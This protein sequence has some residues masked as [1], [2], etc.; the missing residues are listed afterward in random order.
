MG[1]IEPLRSAILGKLVG[2]AQIDGGWGQEALSNH[3]PNPSAPGGRAPQVLAGRAASARGK[4]EWVGR[5][6]LPLDAQHLQTAQRT[7]DNDWGLADRSYL[8]SFR[9]LPHVAYAACSSSGWTLRKRAS[10]VP[11]KPWPLLV[12]AGIDP[13]VD[14]ATDGVVTEVRKISLE[15]V[16]SDGCSAIALFAGSESLRCLGRW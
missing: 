15:K 5:N 12:M 1:I 7:V 10:V 11:S 3:T 8:S 16:S 2:A 4:Q 14:W 13:F 6:W 9:F